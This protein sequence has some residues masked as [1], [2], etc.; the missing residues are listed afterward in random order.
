MLIKLSP[1]LYAF[2]KIAYLQP[3][4]L[5]P[6]LFLV[7]R[8]TVER[9]LVVEKI[10]YFQLI[11]FSLSESPVCF[12]CGLKAASGLSVSFVQG[13]TETTIQPW[14]CGSEGHA[15][16]GPQKHFRAFWC[17]IRASKDI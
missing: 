12:M 13:R 5:S 14:H 1:F 6:L 17:I 7:A 16:L 11:S 3:S 9:V 8:K 2:L 4:I 15:F 10:R